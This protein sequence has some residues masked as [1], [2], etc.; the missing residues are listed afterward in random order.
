MVM[1]QRPPGPSNAAIAAWPS[2]KLSVR[3]STTRLAVCSLPIA[4]LARWVL[5]VRAEVIGGREIQ[6]NRLCPSPY[7]LLR[8]RLAAKPVA[9]VGASPLGPLGIGGIASAY[10]QAHHVSL[11]GCHGSLRGEANAVSN[12]GRRSGACNM[13]DGEWSWHGRRRGRVGRAGGHLQGRRCD[14]HLC[15]RRQRANRQAKS[16]GRLQI[17]TERLEHLES[18][19]QGRRHFREPVRG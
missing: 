16:A 4:K 14:L 19:V 13:L 2:K 18:P 17:T 3:R 5:G 15:Q 8:I 10:T 9:P 6:A 12:D 11:L 1:P 7:Q